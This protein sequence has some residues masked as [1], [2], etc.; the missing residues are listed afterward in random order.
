VQHALQ[1]YC[2]SHGIIHQ[3]LC[4]HTSQ[5]NSV[6][7]S[8]NYLLDIARTLMIHMH[9]LKYFWADAVLTTCHLINRVH[10]SILDSKTPF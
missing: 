1:D 6:A 2:I 4:A 8:K 3:T 5:Q 9:V 10:F 7:E